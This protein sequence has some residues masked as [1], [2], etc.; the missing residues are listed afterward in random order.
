MF[1]D[2]TV[3]KRKDPESIAYTSETI[4]QRTES[5]KIHQPGR[6]KNKSKRYY[7]KEGEEIEIEKMERNSF[8]SRKKI[9]F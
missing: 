7:V 5:S 1:A 8:E 3:L 9:E 6:N 2:D 4:T